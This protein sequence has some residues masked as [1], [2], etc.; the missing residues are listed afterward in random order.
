[1]EDLIQ[2]YLYGAGGVFDAHWDL[3]INN[4]YDEGFC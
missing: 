3:Y 2:K 1:M 4:F